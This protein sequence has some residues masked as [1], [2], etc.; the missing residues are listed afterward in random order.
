MELTN[1]NLNMSDEE[2]LE[3]NGG[4]FKGDLRG[5]VVGEI[6]GAVVKYGS[7]IAKES[8]YTPMESHAKNSAYVRGH[9]GPL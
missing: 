1:L 6:I 8:A 7:Q 4:D 5:W 2:L 3:I 9:G